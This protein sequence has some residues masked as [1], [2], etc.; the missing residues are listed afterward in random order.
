MVDVGPPGCEVEIAR[1]VK[2]RVPNRLGLR[3]SDVAMTVRDKV[4]GSVAT[5]YRDR[6]RH[7]DIRVQNE[8]DQRN[9]VSAIR[10]LI[11]AE[12]DGVPIRLG[13]IATT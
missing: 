1:N 11:V 4:R 7:I 10:E 9:T 8:P 13:A 5:R 12:R 6:E 3:L 2:H